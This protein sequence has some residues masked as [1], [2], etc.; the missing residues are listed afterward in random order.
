MPITAIVSYDGTPNDADALTLARVLGEAGARLLL[1]YVC[2][3]GDTSERESALALLAR[4]SESLEPADVQARVVVHPS[5]SDGLA[6]LAR[7]EQ[8]ELIVFGSEYRTPLGRVAPQRSTQK[9][10]DGGATAIAIAPAAYRQREIRTIGLL[11]GLD[12]EAAIDT[13]HSLANHFC[14][15][16]TDRGH[17][18]DLVIVGSRPEARPGHT[19][20]SAAAENA[21]IGASAPVLVVA[22]GAA[23]ELGAELYIA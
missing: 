14:A 12:D 9:L 19:L 15:D 23:L 2:H 13:A 6:E 4:G 5:T 16:V 3:R 1:A 21:I 8:A 22:R 11:A 17:G 18:V 7:S 10:L 20:L